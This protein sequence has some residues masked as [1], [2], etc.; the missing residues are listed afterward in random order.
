MRLILLGCPGAGK[1]T[2]AKFIAEKFHIPQ[3]STGNILRAAIQAGTALGKKAKELVESGQLVP[4]EM[5]VQLVRDRLAEPDCQNGFL[6]DGFP[7][8]IAQA[9]ALAAITSIDYVI[10][11]DVPAEEI[12]SRLSGRRVHLA[13]G[14]TYHII[15]Q[16]PKM[17]GIDDVTGEPLIQR[18]DDSEET[19]RKR[20][21]VYEEQTMPLRD[22]YRRS[23]TNAY[24]EIDGTGT[25]DDI[26]QQIFN[27]LSTAKA[28]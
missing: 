1:G 2:Q 10:D 24:I 6:L 7:R 27:Y 18:N 3:I 5:V 17:E 14:R 20:L 8:T 25:V 13:S 12:V 19:I 9:E 16:P 26:T 28:E 23:K 15:H 4:D 21:A 22:Y 11:I